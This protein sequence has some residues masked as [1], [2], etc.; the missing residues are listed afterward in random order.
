MNSTTP[1]SNQTGRVISDVTVRRAINLYRQGNTNG[2]FQLL[3]LQDV[4]KQADINA[5]FERFKNGTLLESQLKTHIYVILNGETAQ[6]GPENEAST[7]TAITTTTLQQN[8]CESVFPINDLPLEGFVGVFSHLDKSYVITVCRRV[9]KIWEA[10][11]T[12]TIIGFEIPAHKKF[13]LSVANQHGGELGPMQGALTLCQPNETSSIEFFSDLNEHVIKIKTCVSEV[14]INIDSTN[15]FSIELCTK[16]QNTSL[17]FPNFIYMLAMDKHVKEIISSKL[18]SA[19]DKNQQLTHLCKCLINKNLFKKAFEVGKKIRDEE[20]QGDVFC[21]L[22]LALLKAGKFEQAKEIAFNISDKKWN[23]CSKEFIF[24]YM[25]AQGQYEE[26]M[27]QISSLS[28]DCLERDCQILVALGFR[29]ANEKRF[30]EAQKLLTLALIAYDR[31]VEESHP[32]DWNLLSDSHRGCKTL[33]RLI[34]ENTEQ[35]K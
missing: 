15:L 21:D 34:A 30:E 23:G 24:K 14:L 20:A 16:Q 33:K 17:Y 28:S 19:E 22:C 3:A 27:K 11:A 25:I 5:I 4:Q 32:C 1:T 13:I 26:V 7:S 8:E 2:A 31:A 12:F 6:P 10:A 9:N 18:L 35:K 29:F